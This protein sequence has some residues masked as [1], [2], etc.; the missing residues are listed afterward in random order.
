MES[1][2]LKWVHPLWH[3][4]VLPAA[5]LEIKPDDP[6]ISPPFLSPCTGYFEV[7]QTLGMLTAAFPLP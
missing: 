3:S 4:S 5:K 2:H 7:Q 1:E 6:A